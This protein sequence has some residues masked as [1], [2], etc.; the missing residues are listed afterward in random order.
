LPSFHQL[1]SSSFLLWL[2]TSLQKAGGKR[3]A[4]R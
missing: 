2:S 3:Q 4:G 1:S